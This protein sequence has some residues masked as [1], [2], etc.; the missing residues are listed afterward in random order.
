MQEAII[1]LLTDEERKEIIRV[2]G[3]N[4]SY[5]DIPAYMREEKEAELRQR[6]EE[7]SI[8]ELKEEELKRSKED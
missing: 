2:C 8:D 4:F 1:N 6:Q 7:S 3:P 5:Q